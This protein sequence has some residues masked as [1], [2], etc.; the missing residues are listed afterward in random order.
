MT[1]QADVQAT[2]H[3]DRYGEVKREVGDA[4]QVDQARESVSGILHALLDEHA[5]RA[6]ERDE[7]ARVTYGFGG[8]ARSS[9][10]G[11]Q[12]RTASQRS[13]G[14]PTRRACFASHGRALASACAQTGDQG[15]PRGRLAQDSARAH[16]IPADY[17]PV[18][19]A[20]SPRVG[21]RAACGRPRPYTLGRSVGAGAATA[22][23]LPSSRSLQAAVPSARACP[24]GS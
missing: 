7:L 12:S 19:I 17:F 23:L 1:N 5:R 10:G 15:V 9:L 4:E 8:V 6:L 22:S 3:D 18:A 14:R 13:S 11:S 24:A 2:Q 16:S 21:A 20:H